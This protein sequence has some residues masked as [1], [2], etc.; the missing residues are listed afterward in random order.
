[1]HMQVRY[2]KKGRH[3]EAEGES[4][5]R[6]PGGGVALQDKPADVPHV[7]HW[8]GRPTPRDDMDAREREK[9]VGMAREGEGGREGGWEG[10]VSRIMWFG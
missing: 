3:V 5:R 6:G 2:R 1:M 10:G 4:R 7:R 8:G 9:D